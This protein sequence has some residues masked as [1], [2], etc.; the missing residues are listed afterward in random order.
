[1]IVT[2]T[3]KNGQ[4]VANHDRSGGLANA[5]EAIKSDRAQEIGQ[6]IQKRARRLR[7][8]IKKM[9]FSDRKAKFNL[10]WG[11]PKSQTSHNMDRQRLLEMRERK[12]L[13]RQQLQSAIRASRHS[14]SRTSNHHQ[15]NSNTSPNSR[16]NPNPCSTCSRC[17]CSC[18]R[19]SNGRHCIHSRWQC[20]TS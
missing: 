11:D 8:P 20:F 6:E 3:G 1:V 7:A 15:H 5:A 9:E 19:C 10:R 4:E 17:D 13:Q 12:P 2:A 16:C 18:S 14:S